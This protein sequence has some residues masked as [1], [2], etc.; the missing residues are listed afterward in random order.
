MTNKP[1]DHLTLS[2]CFNYSHV[3]PVNYC[4]LQSIV[5]A[6][7]PQSMNVGG[8]AQKLWTFSVMQGQQY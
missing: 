5:Q 1:V 3:L 2:F 7:N 4:Y 6:T 8:M